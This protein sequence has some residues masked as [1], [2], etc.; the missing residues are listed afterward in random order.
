M[1]PEKL[2]VYMARA[3]L[4]VLTFCVVL[5]LAVAW[6]STEFSRA[7]PHI[8]DGKEI[9]SNSDSPNYIRNVAELLNFISGI[10]AAIAGIAVVLVALWAIRFAR[11]QAYEA[12]KSRQEAENAR[13]STIYM[14]IMERWHSEKLVTARKK[15]FDLLDI[16]RNNRYDPSMTMFTDE[17]QYVYYCLGQLRTDRNLLDLYSYTILIQFFEDVGHLCYKQYIKK[18]DIFDIMGSSIKRQLGY[19]G[20]FIRESRQNQDG[21]ITESLYAN[22]IYLYKENLKFEGSLHKQDM[23]Q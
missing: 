22:A 3:G 6:L 9:I 11:Q 14:N 4:S 15:L 5:S 16:Y 12:T 10:F 18:E 1:T 21:T 17:Q 7:L 13:L 19:Y 8:F 2:T 20:K 23:W